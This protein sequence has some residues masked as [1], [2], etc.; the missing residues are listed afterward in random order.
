[1]VDSF[2][3]VDDVREAPT[4]EDRTRQR[5]ND[6]LVILGFGLVLLSIVVVLIALV[7]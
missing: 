1:M 3:C 4:D 7:R 2:L 6:R 5:R